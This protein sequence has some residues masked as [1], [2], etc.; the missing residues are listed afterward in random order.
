M[1]GW[2]VVSAALKLLALVHSGE[3]KTYLARHPKFDRMVMLHLLPPIG[4]ALEA[5]IL[6]AVGSLPVERRACLIERG[7]Y[8]GSQY[9]VT[10]NQPD[11]R[12]FL[13][14]LG[15]LPE[16]V[17]AQRP[18][19]AEE[20][21]RKPLSDR[22]EPVEAPAVATAAG[23][24]LEE[25]PSSAGEP[26][27]FTRLFET[28]SV[29]SEGPSPIAESPRKQAAEEGSTR[30]PRSNPPEEF[31]RLFQTTGVAEPEAGSQREPSSPDIEAGEFTRMFQA[32]RPSTT[33]AAAPA[34][35]RQAAPPPSSSSAEAGEF[36][37]M[38]Q[39]KP[40]AAP[41]SVGRPPTAHPPT[42]PPPA[43][44][45]GE[46]G[47]FTRMF[48]AK[49]PVAEKPVSPPPPATPSPVP[50]SGHAGEF[51]RV[52][53]PPEAAKPA[54]APAR[55]PAEG[56]G[57]FTRMFQSPLGQGTEAP[58][59]L[60]ATPPPSTRDSGFHTPGEFTRIFGRLSD[61]EAKSPAAP[62]AASGQPGQAGSGD[63]PGEFTRL[64]GPAMDMGPEPEAAVKK[65]QTA[66]AAPAVIKP[67]LPTPPARTK[68]ASNLPLVVVL[69]ALVLLAVLLVLYFAL[70]K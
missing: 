3:I 6:W 35:V 7:E 9:F 10:E 5:Q 29:A 11:Y 68:L 58:L 2:G 38:F 31:T 52:F 50:A 18:A 12:S 67:A 62:P 53:Q 32:P 57:E 17:A 25:E 70:R 8:V 15:P 37:R 69:I 54:S 47:E 49:P 56:P 48:Q 33:T 20:A 40:P 64:F 23:P 65:E 43:A 45:A 61:Q 34:Q 36:T 14:W 30:E 60:N 21:K 13:D 41:K 4:S 66:A 27:E 46:A 59:D 28:P 22:G 63:S 1:L 24:A 51:T 39:A 26:G 42:A 19:P 55:P 44:S 16:A